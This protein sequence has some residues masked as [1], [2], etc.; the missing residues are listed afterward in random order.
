MV[1]TVKVGAEL[2][3]PVDG[4][5]GVVSAAAGGADL[6]ATGQGKQL[7]GDGAAE[8]VGTVFP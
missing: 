6:G 5:D 7:P 8:G 1:V 2:P 3:P 4:R